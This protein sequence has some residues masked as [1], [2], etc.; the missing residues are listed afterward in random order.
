MLPDVP[1]VA[2]TLAALVAPML[3]PYG[4][5]V[6]L[7]TEH[8]TAALITG[9]G[10][11]LLTNVLNVD[12]TENKGNAIARYLLQQLNK[13]DTE[14]G[15]GCTSVILMVA[16]GLRACTASRPRHQY[17]QHQHQHREIR[18][19]RILQWLRK[20]WVENEYHQA[21]TS[22]WA[23]SVRNQDLALTLRSLICT[24][25]TGKF[26]S[27]AVQVLSK[28]V[29]EWMM[30]EAAEKVVARKNNAAAAGLC[31]HAMKARL[32]HILMDWPLLKAAGASLDTSQILDDE[33]L[34]TRPFFR[35]QSWAKH[36]YRPRI[37]Q[38]EDDNKITFVVV[39]GSFA[40]G[41]SSQLMAAP[42]AE[43]FLKDTFANDVIHSASEWARRCVDAIARVGVSVLLCTEA[44]PGE[45]SGHLRRCHILALDHVER[46]EALLLCGR[47]AIE[48]VVSGTPQTFLNIV[49]TKRHS[50]FVGRATSIGRVTLGSINCVYF[51]GLL[52]KHHAIDSSA[53][54]LLLRAGSDGI[55][56]EYERAVRRCCVVVRQW[57]LRNNFS[58]QGH[59]KGDGGSGGSGGNG[60]SGRSDRSDRSDRDSPGNEQEKNT[61]DCFQTVV[62]G[63]G[64]T[65]LASQAWCLH[66][67]SQAKCGGTLSTSLSSLVSKGILTRADIHDGC[68]V[69]S[70]MFGSVPIALAKRQRGKRMTTATTTQKHSGQKRYL[71][72]LA[73]KRAILEKNLEKHEVNNVNSD[74]PTRLDL[75]D[76]TIPIE[77]PCGRFANLTTALDVVIGLLRVNDVLRVRKVRSTGDTKKRLK[78]RFSNDETSSEYEDDEEDLE[79]EEISEEDAW[80]DDF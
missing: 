66:L 79:S 40:P 58:S 28:V 7:E 21:V 32:E 16:A 50:S 4:R 65:E 52:L 74:I 73:E 44:L 63:G 30:G 56:R 6:L 24:N 43:T 22:T 64:Q 14:Y 8:Q 51:R 59:L 77:T 54:Q 45:F 46:R 33:V 27:G 60:R 39:I 70:E 53:G 10:H 35:E 17:R 41:A 42:K 2:N 20:A 23:H 48:P 47:A 71:E 37:K 9:S 34:V 38:Q 80:D 29:G 3:G 1:H 55:L 19:A 12:C 76:G 26:G 62:H 57:L 31:L 69:L 78:R 5:D 25:L 13:H 61:Q 68:A 15:D 49:A 11:V 67:A 18:T 72:E 36:N 75:V